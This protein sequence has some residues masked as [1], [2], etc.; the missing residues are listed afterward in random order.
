MRLLS[1]PLRQWSTAWVFVGSPDGSVYVVEA[2]EPQ[3]ENGATAEV[4][5]GGTT[6][7][8]GPTET[9]V[10]RAEFDAGAV[11]TI[12]GEAEVTADGVE[13]WPVSVNDTG[14][15]GWVNMGIRAFNI[16]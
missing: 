2:A 12:T 15:V 13:W 8:G 4:A 11:V 6:L 1:T 9:A 16:T 3:L 5:D 10:V 14:E 7:R